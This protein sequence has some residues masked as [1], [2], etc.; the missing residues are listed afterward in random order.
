[1][2]IKKKR[3]EQDIICNEDQ[4]GHWGEPENSKFY[5]PKPKVI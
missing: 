2:E 3:I 1:M 5:H 4:F